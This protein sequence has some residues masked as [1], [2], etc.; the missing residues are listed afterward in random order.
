MTTHAR[1]CPTVLAELTPPNLEPTYR[2]RNADL[3]DQRKHDAAEHVYN[4]V[5]AE[6][7]ESLV[8]VKIFNCF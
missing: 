2:W 1:F 6:R 7:A 4:A 5:A 3:A 8:A